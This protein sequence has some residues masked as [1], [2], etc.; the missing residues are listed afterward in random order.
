[1][2]MTTHQRFAHGTRVIDRDGFIGSIC[3]ITDH[4]GS[5]WYDVRFER[6]SAVR[7]PGDVRVVIDDFPAYAIVADKDRKYLDGE[8]IAVPFKSTRH[9]TLYSFYCLGSVAG[10]AVKHGEDVEAAIAQARSKGH[11]LHYAFGLGASLTAWERPK[12][13]VPGFEIGETIRFA[14]KRF[15]IERA[16]N[17]NIGLAEVEQV[18]A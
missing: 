13:I 4:N 7:Y 12:E 6:G 10:Y 3:N 18:P 1:M 5:F 17:Q 16:P 2:T 14:G 8:K 9:G 11:K 15:R